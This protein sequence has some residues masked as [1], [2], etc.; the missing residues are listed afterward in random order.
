MRWTVLSSDLLVFF[1]AALWFVWAYI[2]LGVGISGEERREGWMWLL[3]MVLSSPCLVLIDHGHFQC[4]CI[5]LGLTLG[6]IAGVL[7]RNKLVA[8]ALF[9]LAI[10]HKQIRMLSL[11]VVVPLLYLLDSLPSQYHELR[12]GVFLWEVV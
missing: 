1:P 4:N 5:S 10:N 6:A 12:F 11:S 2:K 7:S 9:T 8:A 3:A